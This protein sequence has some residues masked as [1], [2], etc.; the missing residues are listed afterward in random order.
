MF[1]IWKKK[2]KI[3]ER[4]QFLK[5][6]NYHTNLSSRSHWQ[7]TFLISNLKKFHLVVA[8]VVVTKS[9]KEMLRELRAAR[10]ARSL[11]WHRTSV[12]C[13]LTSKYFS[14]LYYAETQY[15]Q[16]Y[17]ARCRYICDN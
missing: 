10:A 11:A 7:D 9:G 8:V 3:L 5:R 17:F 13:V 16:I 2:D 12:T 15:D 14:V 1:L 4:F 6:G